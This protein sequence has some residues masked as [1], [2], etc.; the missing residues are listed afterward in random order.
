LGC[1][2]GKICVGGVCQTDQCLGITCGSNQYCASGKCI[3]LC[4]PGKCGSN[5]T[6][7]AGA[8]QTDP[9]VNVQC[10]QNY[11][12]NPASGACLPNPCLAM[13]CP[14]GQRCVPSTAG[15][16]TDPCSTINCPSQCWHCGIT[17]DGKGTCLLNN[18]CQPVQ[19]Q[20]GQRGGGESGCSYASGDGDRDV[21]WMGMLLA[22][23][24]VV[25][26]RVGR[27]SGRR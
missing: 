22:L 13:Q 23:G 20:V 16:E 8:C 18:S 14:I 6:C 19:T 1:A 17:N 3:D 21:S 24:L 26:R 12:C 4:E 5:Q 11:F 25:G 9:C 27:R 15:C 10:D 2:T 7:V